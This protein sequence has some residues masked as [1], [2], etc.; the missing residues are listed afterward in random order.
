M[1]GSPILESCHPPDGMSRLLGVCLLISQALP[2]AISDLLALEEEEVGREVTECTR[3]EFSK[4]GP[5]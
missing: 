1:L 2:L 5:G 4:L 3:G